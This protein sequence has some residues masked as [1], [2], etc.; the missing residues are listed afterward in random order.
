MR[1]KLKEIDLLK[2]DCLLIYD[3]YPPFLSVIKYIKM[4][5]SNI[6][7][8]NVVPD[9]YG[10][11]RDSHSILSKIYDKFNNKILIRNLQFVDGYVYLTEFMSE[12]MPIFCQEKKS[13]I[14]EGILHPDVA[15]DTDQDI[16]LVKGKYILYSGSL[17][18]RHGIINLIKAYI[19]ANLLNCKLVICGDGEGKVQVLDLIKQHK[20]VVYL[21]QVSREVAIKIQRNAFLLTNPRT[22]SGVF[23]RYSFPSKII[24]YFAS[25]VPT[26]MYKLDG[27]PTEYYEHCFYLE[28]EDHNSLVEKL[29]E[30]NHL[31]MEEMKLKGR[32]AKNFVTLH[33]NSK[34]QC[35]KILALIESL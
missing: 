24:E 13:T 27:I 14:V 16:D 25:G 18:L 12:K 35:N 19:D 20:N 31:S 32:N 1:H 4:F 11:T 22:S 8:V 21:G 23:T 5:N 17:D 10:M 29:I 15:S 2:Y 26:L 6:K 9:I 7:V 34:V 30:I 33:K 28:K 3:L